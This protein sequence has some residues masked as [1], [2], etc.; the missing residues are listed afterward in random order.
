LYQFADIHWISYTPVLPAVHRAGF[1][2]ADINSL[3]ISSLSIQVYCI[4]TASG[5]RP[6]TLAY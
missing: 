2:D 6:N 4:Q 3:R 5:V 1:P